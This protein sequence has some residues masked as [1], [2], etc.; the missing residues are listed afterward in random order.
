MSVSTL[1]I[2]FGII[3]VAAVIYI[4]YVMRFVRNKKLSKPKDE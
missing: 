3:A 1:A 4:I 2:C